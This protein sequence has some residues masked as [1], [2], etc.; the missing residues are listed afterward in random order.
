MQPASL[1]GGVPI[2]DRLTDYTSPC[3]V[4]FEVGVSL[5]EDTN[6][7]LV[8]R[9]PNEIGTHI[10]DKATLIQHPLE[11]TIHEP[12]GSTTITLKDVHR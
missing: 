11:F 1:R 12:S 10:I 5:G 3:L 4:P 8:Q 2:T 6:K 9:F 7:E